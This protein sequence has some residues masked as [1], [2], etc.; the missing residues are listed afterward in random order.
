MKCPHCLVEF[1]DEE[2]IINLGRDVESDWAIKKLT[3]PNPKCK[4]NIFFLLKGRRK[5][6]FGSAFF[7]IEN[8]SGWIARMDLSSEAQ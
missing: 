4:K 1:H 5:M 3:C 8:F 2:E 6:Q 7:E